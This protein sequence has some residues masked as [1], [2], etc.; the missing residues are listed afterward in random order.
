MI[1]ISVARDPGVL[2][3]RQDEYRISAEA[4][5]SERIY[6]YIAWNVTSVASV[7]VLVHC[8]ALLGLLPS[9]EDRMSPVVT[10]LLR[11]SLL[12]RVGATPD[13]T[14]EAITTVRWSNDTQNVTQDLCFQTRRRSN[15]GSSVCR[16][17]QPP[18]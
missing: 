4:L 18:A 7:G 14:E 16:T 8:A 13:L 17:S 10:Q 6:I 3:T 15:F 11:R 5:H 2:F 12:E 1:D 9:S